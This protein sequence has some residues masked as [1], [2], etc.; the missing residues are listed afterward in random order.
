ME[1]INTTNNKD[2]L[3]K[4]GEFTC[5]QPWL[6]HSVG[7]MQARYTVRLNRFS[8]KWEPMW[9][10]GNRGHGVGVH[11]CDTRVQAETACLVHLYEMRDGVLKI[12]DGQP[13]TQDDKE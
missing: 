13:P 9:W 1:W 3:C 7:N 6:S 12:L 5:Y 8:E 4:D 11:E 2:P 10:H